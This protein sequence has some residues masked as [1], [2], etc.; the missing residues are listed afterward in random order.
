MRRH[1]LDFKINKQNLETRWNCVL[2][3]SKK[4]K[5][6]LPAFIFQHHHRKYSAVLLNESSYKGKMIVSPYLS[7]YISTIPKHQF[8]CSKTVVVLLHV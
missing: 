4:G 6:G 7:V 1:R 5:K 2:F 8:S 3:E